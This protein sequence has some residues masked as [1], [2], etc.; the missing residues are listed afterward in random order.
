MKLDICGWLVEEIYAV[1]GSWRFVLMKR[2]VT[3]TY[4][5]WLLQP[6]S[7]KEKGELDWGCASRAANSDLIENNLC[8]CFK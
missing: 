1:W 6:L 8:R 4:A 2:C 3:Q 5:W 7:C